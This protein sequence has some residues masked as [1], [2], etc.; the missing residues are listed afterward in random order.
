MFLPGLPGRRVGS[1]FASFSKIGSG[2]FFEGLIRKLVLFRIFILFLGFD[3][4]TGF[5]PDPFFEGLIRK[6]VLSRILNSFFFRRS[7]PDFSPV[8]WIRVKSVWILEPAWEKAVPA[9]WCTVGCLL[10]LVSKQFLFRR[11]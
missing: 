6:P 3:P 2:S 4:K 9:L 1:G 11:V 8:G 7:D 5:I 10:G